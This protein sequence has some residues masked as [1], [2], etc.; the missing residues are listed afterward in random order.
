VNLKVEIARDTSGF[1]DI[2]RESALQLHA[3][4]AEDRSQRTRGTTLFANDL[5][6]V[7]GSNV[8]AKDGGFLFGEGFYTDS[9]GIVD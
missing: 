1:Y 8:K 5:A 4:G 2:E 7:A 9:V 3:G 6:N